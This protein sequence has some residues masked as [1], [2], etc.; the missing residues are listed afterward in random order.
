[1]VFASIYSNIFK[2]VHIYVYIYA[3]GK[4]ALSRITTKQ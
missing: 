2:Y 4:W 1:M 3:T